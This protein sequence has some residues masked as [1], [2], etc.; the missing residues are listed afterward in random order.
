MVESMITL[1]Q[2]PDLC[3]LKLAEKTLDCSAGCT[4]PTPPTQSS[5]T[6]GG[7]DVSQGRV[8]YVRLGGILTDTDGERKS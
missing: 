7:T 4:A 3:Y 6:G 1:L 8:G 5:L 2:R